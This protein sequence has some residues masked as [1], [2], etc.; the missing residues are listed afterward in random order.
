MVTNLDGFL[1][2]K[3]VSRGTAGDG[4]AIVL[5]TGLLDKLFHSLADC[6]GRHGKWSLA[7]GCRA[8]FEKDRTGP[9]NAVHRRPALGRTDCPVE[10]TA[11]AC[12]LQYRKFSDEIEKPHKPNCP[13]QRAHLP[14]LV[15][16]IGEMK[17]KRKLKYCYVYVMVLINTLLSFRFYLH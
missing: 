10:N 1:G 13:S 17:R 4:G 5:G 15:G 6:R 9:L 16:T 3:H 12:M 8:T 2:M 7:V 11:Q 14:S